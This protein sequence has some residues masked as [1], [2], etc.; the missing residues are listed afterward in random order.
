MNKR[1]SWKLKAITD[2]SKKGTATALDH[3][4]APNISVQYNHLILVSNTSK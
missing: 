2:N 3:D 4:T 1:K